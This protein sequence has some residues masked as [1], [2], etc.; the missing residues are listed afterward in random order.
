[1]KLVKLDD[2]EVMFIQDS[3]HR[4]AELND[5]AN[6]KTTREYNNYKKLLIKIGNKFDVK[7]DWRDL[8]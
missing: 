2:W 4:E 5:P 1:M 7:I 6:W 8:A 3:I